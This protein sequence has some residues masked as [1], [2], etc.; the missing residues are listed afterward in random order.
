MIYP[1][2]GNTGY[3]LTLNG[4]TY[5]PE[6]PVYELN[7]MLYLSVADFSHLTYGKIESDSSYDYRLSIQNHTLSF[8]SNERIARINQKT[9]ILTHQ[10]LT[11]KEQL[12]LPVNFL[13]LISYPYTLDLENRLLK[14]TPAVPYAKTSDSYKDHI[15]FN[16]KINHLTE[17]IHG[18]VGKDKAASLLQKARQRDD[19]ISF[20]DNTDKTSLLEIM[21]SDLLKGKPLQVGFRQVDFLAPIPKV[22]ALEFM[23]LKV[24]AD[25]LAI[26]AEIGKDKLSYNCIWAAYKPGDKDL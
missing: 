10:P 19:Y 20:I 14:I 24:H 23:P 22:G 21:R 4:I 1:A 16:S 6:H 15:F 5:I 2:Y 26:Y 7:N 3:T 25:N 18:L 13:D 11:L 12:Y 17:A 8:T 9:T